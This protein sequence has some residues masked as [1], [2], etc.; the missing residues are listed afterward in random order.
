MQRFRY[1]KRISM[2]KKIKYYNESKVLKL[3]EKEI[4]LKLGKYA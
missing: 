1:D 2:K 4:F 3:F